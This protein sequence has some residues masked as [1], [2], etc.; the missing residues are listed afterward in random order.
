MPT[1][2]GLYPKYVNIF[3]CRP[4]RLFKALERQMTD[5]EQRLCGDSAGR[6]AT[7]RERDAR[8]LAS[9]VRT[10]EKLRS[11]DAATAT[12]AR[13]GQGDLEAKVVQLRQTLARR[14]ARLAQL[15]GD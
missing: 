10:L 13:S 15:R 9:L 6:G 2:R 4:R 12:Q 7:E 1:G 11:L 3:L 5:V 14:L 8:T